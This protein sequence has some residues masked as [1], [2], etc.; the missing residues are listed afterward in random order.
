MKYEGIQYDGRGMTRM[1][2]R[3]R[4][5]FTCQECG[6]IRTPKQAKKSGKRM[7]DIHHMNGLCGK[8]SKGYDRIADIGGLIT[9]C[10]KCHFNRHDRSTDIIS[11]GN[12][13]R[14]KEILAERLTGKTY[15][16]IGDKYGLSFGR[17]HKICV[18]LS[19]K[20][21]TNV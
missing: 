4:D 21:I 14:N 13:E 11:R 10:H 18:E 1:M 9:L 17:V 5:K 6:D 7:F 16:T 19:T 12:I 20:K 3:I 8:K 15:R 2:A